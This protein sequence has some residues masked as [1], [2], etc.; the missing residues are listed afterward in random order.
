M[1]SIMDSSKVVCMVVESSICSS[2]R[3]SSTSS[4]RCGMAGVMRVVVAFG[5]VGYPVTA[6]FGELPDEHGGQVL[7]ASEPSSMFPAAGMP[8]WKLSETEGVVTGAQRLGSRSPTQRDERGFVGVGHLGM[9][10][11]ASQS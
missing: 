5:G 3:R 2:L 10:W 7:L 9:S 8:D 1:K 4:R 11:F 6:C